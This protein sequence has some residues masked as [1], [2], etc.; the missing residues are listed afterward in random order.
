M[1]IAIVKQKFEVACSSATSLQ[2][3]SN[4]GAA[5]EAVT[6][7]KSL[8]EILTDEVMKEVFMP[9]MNSKIGF[10]TDRTG[11]PGKNGQVMP[12]YS[13]SDVRDCL[14]DG[15]GMGLL[16]TG[17]QMNIIAGRA[18]PTKEGY[19]A[20]LKKIGVKY[21]VNVGFDKNVS[22][23]Y[24][25][26]PVTIPY[27]FNGEKKSLAVVVSVKKDSYSSMDQIRGKAER[28]AKK[29]LYEYLTGTDFGDGD[30]AITPHEEI[31]SKK[32]DIKP[33]QTKQVIGIPKDE[34]AESEP[35]F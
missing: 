27:E 9:L 10:L 28:R 30:E 1:E 35:G 24:A 15:I 19:T 11:K 22:E 31:S 12:L 8:R 34:P 26:V 23:T 18:Y 13:I 4:F 29:I 7:I 3:A 21:L 20:L 32:I 33:D 17:N 6:L 25:E 5:F 16:P 2:I 14:I